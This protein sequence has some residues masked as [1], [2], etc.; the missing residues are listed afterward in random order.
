M[1]HGV[2][3]PG[4]RPVSRR[5]PYGVGVTPDLLAEIWDRATSTQP[6]PSLLVVLLTALLAAA[7]VVTPAAWRV[8]R[9]VVTLVH[10]AGHAGVAL[11]TGRRLAGIRLHSDTSGL[12]TSVGRPSGPGMV[13][14]AAAGYVAPGLLG[15][16]AAALA[17]RG[18]AVGV[19]W[20]LLGLVALMGLAV[21]NLFGL[22]S[23]LVTGVVLAGVTWWAPAGWQTSA[24]WTVT[25]FLLLAGPRPVLELQR[26]R[27]RG[28]RTSDADV[29]ARLTRVP[30]LVWVAGFLA[31]TVATAVAGGALL[32]AVA[33]LV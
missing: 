24:A 25:W 32:T 16:G 1:H 31:A 12:T 6:R 18:Y 10:E 23:L 14:T 15:L 27:R 5:G 21:R 28:A 22:W 3:R 26:T 33:T 4:V 13:A 11:L 19:L 29:L 7:V 17:S 9:H 20:C 2:P 30:A 8:A